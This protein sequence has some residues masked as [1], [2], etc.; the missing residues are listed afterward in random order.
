MSKF[1][2][3]LQDLSVN[4]DVRVKYRERTGEHRQAFLDLMQTYD[5]TEE[6]QRA[7]LK[8]D[9]QYVQHR[10]DH[11][12]GA[13]DNAII[14]PYSNAIIRPYRNDFVASTCLPEATRGRMPA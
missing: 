10:L 3:F 6:E 14:R 4:P 5:L 2:A 8:G 9:E 13:H 12:N 7:V 11:G 1:V